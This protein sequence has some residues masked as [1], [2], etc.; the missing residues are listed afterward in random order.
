[1]LQKLDRNKP[2]NRKKDKKKRLLL[3]F[4]VSFIFF[5]GVTAIGAHMVINEPIIKPLWIKDIKTLEKLKKNLKEENITYLKIERE[6]DLSYRIAIKDNG[7][8]FISEKKDLAIQIDSLQLILNRLTIEGK[9]FKILD[10][11]FDKPVI[12]Y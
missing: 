8:V 4:C 2:K 5:C 11:R 12:T 10:F 1:M 9:R 7:I 6:N 3:F